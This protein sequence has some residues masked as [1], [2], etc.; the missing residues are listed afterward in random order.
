MSLNHWHLHIIETLCDFFLSL[1]SCVTPLEYPLSCHISRV[2]SN[3]CHLTRT[4]S[5][6]LTSVL[7]VS[8]IHLHYSVSSTFTPLL[9]LLCQA[10]PSASDSLCQLI[11]LVVVTPLYIKHLF[12]LWYSSL[13]QL[14][15][16]AVVTPLCQAPFPPLTLCFNSPLSQL[17]LFSI[18]STSSASDILL[19]LSSSISQ[20]LLLSSDSAFSLY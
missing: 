9:H 7:P 18:S 15:S 1:S 4:R 20:L 16:L 6:W 11:S 5:L 14:T 13:C 19:C 2:S 17:L 3:S 12:C 10:P 8:S